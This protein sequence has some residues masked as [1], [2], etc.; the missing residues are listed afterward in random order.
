MNYIIHKLIDIQYVCLD[1]RHVRCSGKNEK[2]CFHTV[3][4]RLEALQMSRA[5]AERKLSG[6]RSQ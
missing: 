3:F 5:G 1:L 6:K 4:R 2:Y